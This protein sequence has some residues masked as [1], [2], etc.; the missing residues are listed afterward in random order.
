MQRDWGGGWGE[1][2]WL[3]FSNKTKQMNDNIFQKIQIVYYYIIISGR[4][5][6]IS[7]TK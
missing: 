7:N 6:V 1:A 5:T 3:C 4:N 2:L